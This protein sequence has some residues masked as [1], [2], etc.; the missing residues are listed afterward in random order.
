[1]VALLTKLS[2]SVVP[3]SIGRRTS[4]TTPELAA[5][6]ASICCMGQRA[7][8]GPEGEDSF[9]QEGCQ[10]WSWIAPA[11]SC[12][13]SVGKS[14]VCTERRPLRVLL[15]AC[16]LWARLVEPTD[17]FEPS[18]CCLRNSCSTTEL[19]WPKSGC[20]GS[21]RIHT[22]RAASRPSLRQ[23]VSCYH[24][25]QALGNRGRWRASGGVDR[26]IR[27][28]HHPFLP[29]APGIR[30]LSL[31]YNNSERDRFVDSRYARAGGERR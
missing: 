18:T 30:M 11:Q 16:L 4:K 3:D 25:A 7:R 26:Q 12:E 31:G 29:F 19:R 24:P 10:A 5:G 20:G 28:M 22:G 27:R 2:E 17:G 23:R 9:A 14:L 1:M 15:G 13:Q 21:N 8:C 6:L